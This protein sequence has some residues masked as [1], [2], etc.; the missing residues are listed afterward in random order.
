MD[1]QQNA[2]IGLGEGM[3]ESGGGLKK[4][5]ILELLHSHKQIKSNLPSV[6]LTLI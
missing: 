5:T 2:F 6:P 4:G 1:H 3:T